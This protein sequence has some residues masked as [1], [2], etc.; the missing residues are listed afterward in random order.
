MLLAA[1]L[2][3]TG[4]APDRDYAPGG[5]LGGDLSVPKGPFAAKPPTTGRLEVYA[6]AYREEVANTLFSG[7]NMQAFIA[8]DAMK[9]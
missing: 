6:P 9:A 2:A 3:P 7:L 4:F 5:L 8:C 1:E